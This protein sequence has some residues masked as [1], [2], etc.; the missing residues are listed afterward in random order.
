MSTQGSTDP[1]PVL[2]TWTPAWA[3]N[4]KAHNISQRSTH[5]HQLELFPEWAVHHRKRGPC[6]PDVIGVCSLDDVNHS[7][8]AHHDTEIR[9]FENPLNRGEIYCIDPPEAWNSYVI[10]E[11]SSPAV[12]AIGNI[13]RTTPDSGQPSNP[14]EGSLL[15]PGTNFNQVIICHKWTEVERDK[16]AQSF[17]ISWL[18]AP[19]AEERQSGQYWKS[20]QIAGL[21]E[22]HDL[23]TGYF[24]Q[25]KRIEIMAIPVKSNHAQDILIYTP[26]PVDRDGSP[27]SW[28]TTRFSNGFDRIRD[29]YVIAAGSNN[30]D[31]ILLASREGI[32]FIWF[33][34]SSWCTSSIGSGIIPAPTGCAS[35]KGR[36]RGSS[37]VSI[38]R[39][40]N[41]PVGFVASSED[42]FVSVYVKRPRTR[43]DL[44]IS[45]VS[46]R[47][48]VIDQ[49]EATQSG[50]Q[51]GIYLYKPTDLERGLFSKFKLA[52]IPSGRLILN[53]FQCAG[54][55]DVVTMLSG[56]SDCTL[57]SH[58]SIKMLANRTPYT[59]H[60]ISVD[61]FNDAI[62][63]RIPRPWDAGHT[64]EIPIFELAGKK[65]SLVVLPVRKAYV[66]SRGDGIKI[67]NGERR[68]LWFNP[69]YGCV[70]RGI[71][72]APRELVS[73]LPDAESDMVAAGERGAVFLRFSRCSRAGSQRITDMDQLPVT[74]L[75]PPYVSQAARDKTWTW[76]LVR[77]KLWSFVCCPWPFYT[78]GG[79]HVSY[80]DESIEDVVH[81]Q[82]W[83]L[84]VNRTVMFHDHESFCEIQ[85]YIVNGTGR[86]GMRW[87]NSEDDDAVFRD[88]PDMIQEHLLNQH[89]TLL[90]CPDMSEHGPLWRQTANGY[91]LLT[92][93]GKINYPKHASL[94]GKA[95]DWDDS[96]RSQHPPPRNGE[97]FDVWLS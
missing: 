5:T 55:L 88:D 46:W 84:G 54:T 57:S 3:P 35:D 69:Q 92:E 4:F 10:Q 82:G 52:D 68:L 49:F 73:M 6:H 9:V 50:S 40:G 95:E 41:D 45:E 61:L 30:K 1:A 43:D 24:T 58:P 12:V 29:V 7:R 53:D 48:F 38:G 13:R 15:D 77:D 22:L 94:A 64:D 66:L 25:G 79:I 74:S 78:F 93:E 65:V 76:G 11:V 91:P 63:L 72:V 8:S 34:G 33:D 23:R 18:E 14:S 44:V 81:F 2:S 85:A 26:L 70:Q 27:T 60:S 97:T 62:T 21:P 90:E 67:L 56:D 31:R 42:K 83:T 75:L 28:Q 80:G 87:S 16:A 47:R 19:K 17:L 39:V 96:T 86:G 37:R 59:R 89:S 20:H 32:S 71:A 36:F 51:S